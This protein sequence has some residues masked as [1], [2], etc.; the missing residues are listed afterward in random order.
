MTA[1]TVCVFGS[2][3]PQPGD[4]Y[5]DEARNLGGALAEERLFVCTGGYGGIMEAVSRG[6]KE[7]GGRTIGITMRTSRS[8]ANQ[9][10]DQE[11]QASTWQERL[12]ELVKRGSAYVICPGG[13][14]TLVELAV[15]WEMMNK[16][17]MP[18]KPTVVLGNFWR[19]VIE[20]V[21]NA[22]FGQRLASGGDA[23]LIHFADNATEA[24]SYISQRLNIHS[25]AR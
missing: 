20:C 15:V 17:A 6:A 14:G 19:P 3:H 5:Y 21:S 18:P 2:A 8:R 1:K 10:V 22:E 4:R 16:G 25:D 7:M 11:I 24:C 9:W 12:F 23:P 13:T